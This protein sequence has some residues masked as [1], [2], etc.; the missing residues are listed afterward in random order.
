[1]KYTLGFIGCGNMG[2][3]LVRAAAKTVKGD[4]IAVSD[5]DVTKTALYKRECGAIPTDSGD[6]AK[7]AAFVVLG[8]KPQYMES[9]I[10]EFA[11]EL[12]SRTDVTVVTMAA[13]LS[14][15]AIR[16]YIGA[17]LPIIRIMPNTA[18]T[19][20]EGMILY[21]A[22]GVS[23]ETVAEFLH[24][25]SGAGRFDRIPESLIDAGSA[26]SGCG[27]AFVY[28][29]A[30]ALADGAVECGIPRDKAAMYAAQTLLGSAKMLLEYGH[31]GDLKDA[32]CS[33]G[34]TTIAGVHALERN[35]FRNAAMDAVTAAYKRTLELKK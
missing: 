8:L 5:R 3:A 4:R 19:V 28:L 32:V 33:P 26:I 20:G 7:N 18:A 13:G 24:A 2:G 6:I 21:T 1:M 14:M 17:D 16:G 22:D 10:A 30:E 34:G 9:G 25:F 35:G 15:A 23:E 29:F 11:Q 12:S 27:P 31:P